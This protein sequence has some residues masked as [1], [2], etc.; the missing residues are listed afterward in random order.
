G[1]A[2]ATFTA[3]PGLLVNRTY[4]IRV[5]TAALSASGIA[6]PAQFTQPTGFATVSP[7]ICDGSV[8]ISQVYGGGGGASPTYG[9]DFIE[10]HNRGSVGVNVNGWAVQYASGTGTT[11]SKTALSNVS[12][13]AGGYYLVQEGGGSTGTFL[14]L[15]PPDATGTIAMAATAGKVALTNNATALT[16]ACPTGGAIVDF[17]GY[18]ATASCFEGAATAPAPSSTTADF[19]ALSGCGDLNNNT[20]DFATATPNP[21]NSASATAGCACNIE[22]ESGAALEA[23]YCDTQFPLSLSGAS[24]SAQTVFGR[25]FESGI[26]GTGSANAN[27]RAQLGYGPASAN[28]E[29]EAGWTWTNA[30]YNTTCGVA[31]GNNDEYQA[32]FNLPAVGTYRYV[33]RFSLDQGL[34][35]TVCDN[36]QDDFGAGSNGGL[37]FEFADEAVLTSQ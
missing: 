29:Y 28:P 16:G 22:N 19:R 4:Q 11:W 2:T 7:N 6:L 14:V 1:N 33:Y 8:V 37:S 9:N 24:G 23:D 20:G 32:T 5:T 26:T 25:L 17:V 30:T 18:G 21:R 12:I 27:V 13:P 10:L 34:S 15:P 36:D 31:C 3:A 35:W